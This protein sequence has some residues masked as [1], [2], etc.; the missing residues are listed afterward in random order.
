[1]V[2]TGSPRINI[3]V[4]PRCLNIDRVDF[5]AI[6]TIIKNEI[7]ENS[8]LEDPIIIGSNINS[9]RFP[10]SSHNLFFVFSTDRPGKPGEPL[11]VTDVTKTSCSLSWEKPR[12]LGGLENTPDDV[13]YAVE[14]CE[15]KKGTWV[16]VA[17]NL[18]GTQFDVSKLVEGLIFE[19]S[20]ELS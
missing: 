11:E 14:K 16:P 2:W 20:C 17:S 9:L 5:R 3:R 12:D 6:E 8:W 4:N 1:M 7:T 15:A 19:K 18:K 10:I 13:T